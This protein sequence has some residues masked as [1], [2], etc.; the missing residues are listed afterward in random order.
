VHFL[1][2]GKARVGIERLWANIY[3]FRPNNIMYSYYATLFMCMHKHNAVLVRAVTEEYYS[4]SVVVYNRRGGYV[5]YNNIGRLHR[6]LYDINI[7]TTYVRNKRSLLLLLLLLL[8]PPA[9]GTCIYLHVE[10]SKDRGIVV[11]SCVYIINYNIF[12]Y[13]VY[14]ILLR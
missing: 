3:T 2:T 5:H 11:I 9:A 12:I 4:L 13:N 10:G 6:Y 7:S 1:T 8:L 14:I